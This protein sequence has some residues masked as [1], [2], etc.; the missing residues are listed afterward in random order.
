MGWLLCNRLI[1]Y[2]NSVNYH[3][4]APEVVFTYGIPAFLPAVLLT[5]V[6][7]W[8]SALI[9]ARKVSKISPIEAIRQGDSVKIKSH[10]NIH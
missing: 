1:V 4:D 3:T 2:I 10:I 5:I 8:I 9:P 6:T 7:V